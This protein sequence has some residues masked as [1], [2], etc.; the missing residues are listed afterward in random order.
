[1]R[2]LRALKQAAKLRTKITLATV[3]RQE[4]RWSS[5]FAMLDRY[6]RLREFLSDVDE[7]IAELLPTRDTHRRLETLRDE[8]RDVESISKKLQ[9]DG[10]TLLEVRDLFDG[11]LELPDFASYLARATNIVHSP[12][13]E[14]GVV[15]VLS[16]KTESLSRDERAVLLPFKRKDI[17]KRRKVLEKQADT[18]L[19]AVPPTFNVV[20][21]VFISAR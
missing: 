6:A 15:K 10:L 21:R 20:E 14:S 17:L 16:K 3:L 12:E 8:L 4:T 18:L 13:F 9:T 1:M 7:D 5:T 19:T 2:K 11:L